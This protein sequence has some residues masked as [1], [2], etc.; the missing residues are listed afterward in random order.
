METVI[1]LL[2]IVVILL[3]VVI[4]VLLAAVIAVLVKVN[5]IAKRVENITINLAS[6][7]EWLSPVK[8]LAEVTAAIKKLF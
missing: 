2:T 8:M 4:V 1:T 3:S 6:A 5:R 7:T